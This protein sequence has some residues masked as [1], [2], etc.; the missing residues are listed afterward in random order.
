LSDQQR[1]IVSVL[2]FSAVGDKKAQALPTKPLGQAIKD[3]LASA[4]APARRSGGDSDIT[5]SQE[6]RLMLEAKRAA[7]QQRL[8]ESI[9]AK[10]VADRERIQK[11][12]EESKATRAGLQQTQNDAKKRALAYRIGDITKRLERIRDVM[13]SALMWG[14]KHWAVTL[15]KEAAQLAKDLAAAIR[16]SGNTHMPQGDYN[17]ST[18]NFAG[19][20]GEG[21]AEGAEGVEIV[22]NIDVQA[23]EP[24]AE[25]GGAEET[26]ARAAAAEVENQAAE[27]GKL[28]DVEGADNQDDLE[29][30]SPDGNKTGGADA[31]TVK[32]RLEAI[33]NKVLDK[34]KEPNGAG[35]LKQAVDE[36]KSL[37]KEIMSMA[38]QIVR[39]KS[40]LLAIK[41]DPKKVAKHLEDV[42]KA[43]KDISDTFKEIDAMVV[44]AARVEAAEIEIAAAAESLE[45]PAEV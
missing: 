30:D 40:N 11:A 4:A 39:Q 17:F 45:M 41:E 8:K 13:R 12:L 31:K 19:G 37:L 23:P 3:A 28:E 24:D 33:R 18:P 15:A 35:W 7:D 32:D 2:R 6:A 26:E 34:T 27:A 1:C 9:E 14:D 36:I 42:E 29:T 22:E 25:A 5:I 20:D 21:Q 38:K 10:K 16:S 44:Q 43:E